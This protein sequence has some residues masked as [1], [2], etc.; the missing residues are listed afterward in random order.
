[1]KTKEELDVL[2]N[3][4]KTLNAKLA[5]LNED[6]LKEV[7]GGGGPYLGLGEKIEGK[8]YGNVVGDW[9]NGGLFE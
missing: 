2:K 6:E 1:M 7:T 4:V 5:E 9:E 3:E 8:K